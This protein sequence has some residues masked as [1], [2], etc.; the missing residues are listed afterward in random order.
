MKKQVTIMID[1]GTLDT[2]NELTRAMKISRSSCVQS[3]LITGLRHLPKAVLGSLEI[4]RMID[5]KDGA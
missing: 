1:S 2:I 4:Q 3:V 5:R